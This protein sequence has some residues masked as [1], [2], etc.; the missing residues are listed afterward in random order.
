MAALFR[1]R[2]RLALILCPEMGVEARLKAMREAK[3]DLHQTA[4]TAVGSALTPEKAA[5]FREVMEAAIAGRWSFRD[6]ADSAGAALGP[7]PSAEGRKEDG[8]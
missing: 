3:T 4:F 2:H 7:A 6:L 1:L 8:Q 5:R